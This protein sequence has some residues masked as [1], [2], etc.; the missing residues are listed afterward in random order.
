MWGLNK[1][2]SKVGRFIDRHGYTQ[3]ELMKAAKIGRSTVSRVCSDPDY[4]PSG[5]TIKKIMKA[6]RQLDPNA[7]TDDFFDM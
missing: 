7:K 5:S 1:K 4:V 2:R 6:I 3:E